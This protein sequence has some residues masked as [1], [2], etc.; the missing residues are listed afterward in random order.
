M[1]LHIAASARAGRWL[2]G[3]AVCVLSVCCC[4]VWHQAAAMEQA[5][6]ARQVKFS[7]SQLGAGP[8][9]LHG[10]RSV[11][12]I[13]IG[14]RMDEVVTAAKL[15]L[16]LTYSPSLLSG[17]SHLRISLNG[18]V[19]AALQFST[20]QAGREVEREVV[21]DSR[22]F[23]DYNQ[24]RFDFVGHY[25]R[26]C[27][28]AEH[29][30]LWA[31]ISEHSELELSLLPLELRNDLA[32][33]PVPFFDR[34]DN[35]RLEL[36]VVL[37]VNPSHDLLRSAGVAASWFGMLADYRSARF[38]VSFDELP[39]S[40]AL[41]FATNGSRP[42]HLQLADVQQ[43]TVSML[44]HPGR[45]ATKLL[46]FQGK[47]EAQVR[48]AV[49]AVVLGNP[50]LSGSVATVKQIHYERRAAYDAPRWLRS[51]RPVQLGELIDAAGQL[52]VS[53]P[54]PAP[55]R[56]NLRL[57]PDLFTWNHAGVPVDL[58]YRYTAPLKPDSSLL[59]VSINNQLL[60][61]YRLLPQ[62]EVAAAGKLLV[63]LFE[64]LGAQH[65]E[66]LL[67]PAFQ[68][69]SNNQMQFDFSLASHRSGLCADIA[70]GSS[71]AAIDAD[72]T[73]DISEF[74]HYTAMPEL[75]LFANSGYPFTRYADLAETTV[76]LPETASRQDI[77]ELFFILG[78]MGRYTGTAAVAYHL[79]GAQQAQQAD[80]TDL[81]VLGRGQSSRLL[82]RW[83]RNL[84]LVLDDADRHFSATSAARHYSIDP[85]RIGSAGEAAR[86]QVS[87]R[88]GGSLGALMSFE[89]PLHAGRTVVAFAG[90]DAQASQALLDV[91]ED[92]GAVSFIRGDLAVV[93]AGAVQSYR[94]DALYYVGS[95]S[96]WQ[97]LWFHLSRHALLL[98]F[99]VLVIAVVVAMVIHGWL[100]RRAAQRLA[101]QSA[102]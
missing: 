65:S 90:T 28:D 50:V 93:R 14:T 27:E 85:L 20:E 75:A 81:L 18:Q 45:P 77:E 99:I 49:E 3:L 5:L 51:D 76:L 70:G 61:S 44:D 22:Y 66:D 1:N 58:R 15:R 12:G 47:D 48:Q 39:A 11:G 62:S 56:V 64:S 78:R 88:A 2:A 46:V 7:F 63:P 16:R 101:G 21:L 100:Q 19:L 9:E 68:L 96:W 52:Q 24:I 26:Q 69:T 80:D 71:L 42:K 94:S 10:I 60:R 59:N 25:S 82:A 55:I 8:M 43:P 17:L 40:H 38:P 29:S 102:A 6:P 35:R 74:P 97:W 33:L 91:L 32:L 89:S 57:P 54:A 79:M 67:I 86:S 84:S 23:S 92:E 72:S 98:T 37:P 36:P 95:L 4:G 73:I 31:V 83:G 30:S 53:G 87:V 34:R 13:N 41:V